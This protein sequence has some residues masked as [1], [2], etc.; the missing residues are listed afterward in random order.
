VAERD[1]KRKALIVEK[2]T[3]NERIE[4]FEGWMENF[5]VEKTMDK[6][7]MCIQDL[8]RTFK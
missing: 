5:D 8:N 1:V 6:I 2:K 7:I 3:L 4:T